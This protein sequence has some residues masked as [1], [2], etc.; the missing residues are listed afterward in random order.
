MELG[1]KAMKTPG[2]K[3]SAF[4]LLTIVVVGT[5]ALGQ[6]PN[7]EARRIEPRRDETGL[8]QPERDALRMIEEGRQTFRFDTFGD[9]SFWGDALKLH[10]ALAG[11]KLGGVGQGVSPKTALEVG[12]K[13]DQDALPVDVARQIQQ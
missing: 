9:E 7:R 10:F 8:Q 11:E 2:K 1:D 12:L 4:A 6:P 3:A 5:L 13:V